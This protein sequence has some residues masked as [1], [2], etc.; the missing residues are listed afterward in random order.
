ML[1]K[2][3]ALDPTGAAKIPLM[4]RAASAALSALTLANCALHRIPGDALF[5]LLLV[6]AG[7]GSLIWF[8][9]EINDWSLGTWTRGAQIDVPTPPWMIAGF[10][11]IA[12][13]AL[14]VVVNVRFLRIT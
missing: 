12:L 2:R 4:N 11:W 9:E 5:G 10:G 1:L 13:L 14:V 7:C 6:M 3:A 8:P